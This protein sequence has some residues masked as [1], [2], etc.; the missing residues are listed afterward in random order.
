MLPVLTAAAFLVFAQAFMVAPILPRL[1]RVFE[2]DVGLVGLAVP[3]YLIPYGLMTLLWGPWADRIGA[4]SVIIVSLVLFVGLTAA[5]ATAPGAG[6]FVAWRVATGVG[7]SGIVPT[8]LGLIGDLVPYR[9][10][11]HAIGWLF[12]GMAGGMAVG[13]TAGAL[14]EPYIGWRGLFVVV[15]LLGAVLLAVAWA[16]VPGP[17]RRLEAARPAVVA[18]GYATLL[19]GHRARRTYVYVALNAVL[20]SGVYTWLGLYLSERFGLGPVGVGLALMG[21]GLPGFALGPL[22]GRRAD[23]SGRARLVPLGVAIGG[24]AALG[25]AAPVPLAVAVAL[26]TV[27]SLGYDLT[28]PLLAGIV[29]DLPGPR[30]QAVSFMAVTLFSGFGLGSLL[31]QAALRSGFTVALSGFG[32]LALVAAVVALPVFASERARAA[33][34]DP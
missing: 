12:G 23:R 25:L 18:R 10:R 19:S 26:V 8:S 16:R 2:A 22:V 31:F 14:A 6:S 17:T 15:A 29:T 33:P 21:Y 28:Q 1:A 24:I 9:R 30:G 32:L 3:G 5:T 7:A 20:H 13:S 27:L 34:I 4:R 11:G